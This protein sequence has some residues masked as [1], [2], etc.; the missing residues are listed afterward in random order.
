MD[1]TIAIKEI[2]NIINVLVINRNI[3]GD[4]G[5]VEF[6]NLL[7]KILLEG[8]TSDVGVASNSK[9]SLLEKK[10][11]VS[12]KKIEELV[13]NNLGI[14]IGIDNSKTSVLN[15]SL[16][17]TSLAPNNVINLSLDSA[18]K[19]LALC[20][21]LEALKPG[22]EVIIKT[23]A[24]LIRIDNEGISTEDIRVDS[25]G[26]KPEIALHNTKEALPTKGIVSPIVPNERS[27]EDIRVDSKGTKPEIALHNTKEALP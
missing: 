17:E 7:L 15:P 22:D 18:P 21:I 10:E 4:S 5:N 16:I 24:K 11:T 27:A 14:F 6:E 8:T 9:S 23:D 3:Q 25:K 1:Y 2:A 19:V 13:S 20:S 12:K 26:T